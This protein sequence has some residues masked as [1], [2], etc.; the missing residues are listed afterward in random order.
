MRE[1]RLLPAVS[2]HFKCDTK[3]QDSGAKVLILK[4]LMAFCA[5]SHFSFCDYLATCGLENK[6]LSAWLS[7]QIPPQR[8]FRQSLFTPAFGRGE[9]TL[10]RSSVIRFACQ[11]RKAKRRATG[12]AVGWFPR[13]DEPAVRSITS[14]KG[15]G[16]RKAKA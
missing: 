13:P 1:G 14:D 5:V 11:T 12:V 16:L 7:P 6:F 4:W 10:F 9:E 2:E 3:K 8:L 15:N